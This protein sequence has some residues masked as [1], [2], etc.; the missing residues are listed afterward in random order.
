MARKFGVLLKAALQKI[1]DQGFSVAG[2]ATRVG[3]SPQSIYAAIREERCVI[4]IDVVEKIMDEAKL[5]DDARHELETAWLFTRLKSTNLG[6]ILVSMDAE[7]ARRMS[8][9]EL[10]KAHKRLL[11]Q[12]RELV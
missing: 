5:D 10:R 6:K 4:G 2:V 3:V 9:D 8:P 12:Y 1:R 7:L 11:A